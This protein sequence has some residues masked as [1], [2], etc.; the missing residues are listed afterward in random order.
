VKYNNELFLQENGMSSETH[1]VPDPVAAAADFE[2]LLQER[3][4]AIFAQ[5]DENFFTFGGNSIRAAC[6]QDEFG[7]ELPLTV[8][9]EA[10]TVAVFSAYVSGYLEGKPPAL[11]AQQG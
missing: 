3:L 6:V 10:P 4:K 2:A 11:G 9:F 7:I 8:L 5:A 1:E